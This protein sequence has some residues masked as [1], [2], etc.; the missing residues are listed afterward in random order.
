[1]RGIL[2]EILTRFAE[3]D[4]PGNLTELA[5]LIRRLASLPDAGQ[6]RD[7]V[8][9]H[10][11]LLRPVREFLTRELRELDPSADLVELSQTPDGYLL[12]VEIPGH[13]GKT[14]R[15][16]MH[17]IDQARVNPQ[18]RRDLKRILRSELR[19]LRSQREI[20][21]S[22]E[23]LYRQSEGGKIIFER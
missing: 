12:R 3:Y 5:Q 23:V 21:E 13:L 20:S 15:V 1:M 17:Q 22:R 7:E 6:V 16:G 11:V 10:L 18:F 14:L 19:I 9:A 8:R 2:P 4:W